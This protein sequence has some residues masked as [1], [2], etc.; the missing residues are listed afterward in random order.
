MISAPDQALD[1]LLSKSRIGANQRL[2]DVWAE[3]AEAPADPDDRLAGHLAQQFLLGEEVT[4]QACARLQRQ[5]PSAVARNCLAV[6]YED[7]TRHAALY[8]R[9]LGDKPTCTTNGDALNL[10]GERIMAWRGPPE[11]VIL[12][13]HVILEGEALA[14]QETARRFTAC[15]RFAALSHRIARDEARHVAFGQH[16]LPAALAETAAEDR[17]RMYLWLRSLWFDCMERL[18]AALNL[19]SINRI[20]ARSWTRHRWEHWRSRLLA[21]GLLDGEDYAPPEKSPPLL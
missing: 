15:P 16:Y 12:A 3:I 4:A 9:F 6:Q 11:A 14:H 1:R 17:Y 19:S 13:I 2:E 5:L 10:I 7:E 21:L 18:P 8:R 20:L